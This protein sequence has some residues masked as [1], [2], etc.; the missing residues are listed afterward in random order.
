MKASVLY[1]VMLAAILIPPALS[2]AQSQPATTQ[3]NPLTEKAVREWAAQVEKTINAGSPTFL[4]ESVDV[5][6]MADRVWKGMQLTDANR[7]SFLT[8]LPDK[9][10]AFWRAVCVAIKPNGSFRLLHIRQADGQW[11][12]MFRLLAA[13]GVNYDDIILTSGRN[14]AVRVADIYLYASGEAVSDMFGRSDTDLVAEGTERQERSRAIHQ[15]VKISDHLK[16]KEF[17]QAMA[18]FDKIPEKFRNDKAVLV[19]R[20]MA[21]S[22]VSNEEHTKAIEEFHVAFPGDPAG[23]LLSI[24]WYFLD[25]QYKDALDAIDRVEKSI[26]GDPYL[27]VMRAEVFLAEGDLDQ[28]ASAAAR[29]VKDDPTMIQGYW[30]TVTIALRRQDFQTVSQTLTLIENRFKMQLG[31]PRQVPLYAEFVKSPEYAA[32]MASRTQTLA[33]SRAAE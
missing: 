3:A 11:V 6:A 20:I 8:H 2:Q 27:N 21:A 26:G 30:T 12:A 29:A 10:G 18:V 22:H 31:D 9:I 13:G 7:K 24:D 15:I 25:K 32:W 17:Q 4:T 14:G 16:A 1:F 19:M 5:E 33:T 23:D 28:A